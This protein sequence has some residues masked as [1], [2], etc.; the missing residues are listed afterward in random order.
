MDKEAEGR[1]KWK[2]KNKD[3]NFD[4]A[5]WHRKSDAMSHINLTVPTISFK[6]KYKEINQCSFWIVVFD[7]A[8]CILRCI[9]QGINAKC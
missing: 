1:M 7:A 3:V 2:Q 4:V 8:Y 6:L 5:N 9:E